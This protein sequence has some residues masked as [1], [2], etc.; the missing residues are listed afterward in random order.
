MCCRAFGSDHRDNTDKT[1]ESDSSDGEQTATPSKTSNINANAHK[2]ISG[3]VAQTVSSRKPA[4]KKHKKP[5]NLLADLKMVNED[6]DKGISAA[7]ESSENK[8]SSFSDEKVDQ[9][10]TTIKTEEKNVMIL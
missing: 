3:R 9:E 8:G 7:Q 2:I 5:E 4:I 6:Q 1:S 10:Q